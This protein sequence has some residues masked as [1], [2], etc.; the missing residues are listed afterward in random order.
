MSKTMYLVGAGV[1]ALTFLV[2]TVSSAQVVGERHVIATPSQFG[3]LR[4]ARQGDNDVRGFDL[5]EYRKYNADHGITDPGDSRF[6]AMEN[7]SRGACK[8]SGSW[9]ATSLILKKRRA[10]LVGRLPGLVDSNDAIYNDLVALGTSLD[11]AANARTGF[12]VIGTGLLCAIPGVNLLYC[13][14]AAANGV[15]S[16]IG[17]RSH[18]KQSKLNR[19]QSIL[20][21]DIV[22]L[23]LETRK[24]DFDSRDLDLDMRI[25]WSMMIAGYCE[26]HQ[27]DAYIEGAKSATANYTPAVSRTPRDSSGERAQ[28]SAPVNYDKYKK[29]GW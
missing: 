11:R 4:A 20:G 18:K 5:A 16:E 8:Q 21:S 13:G 27:P 10:D 22:D 24:L 17:S 15:N 14:G 28:P 7:E 9:I 29:R 6:Y 12:T 1:L 26:T 2:P 23:D 3:G 25:G 19:R